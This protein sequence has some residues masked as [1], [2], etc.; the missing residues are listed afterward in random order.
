MWTDLLQLVR[1]YACMR[2]NL[3]SCGKTANN[4]RNAKNSIHVVDFTSFVIN[5]LHQ[6]CENQNWCNL[7]FAGLFL[8]RLA[9]SLWIKSLDNQRAS[10]PGSVDN[11][12]Q[13]CYHQAGASDANASWYR[14]D[15]WKAKSLLLKTSLLILPELFQLL[16][17]WCNNIVTTL[18]CQPCNILVISWLYQTC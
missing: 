4:A 3:A 1:F 15:D 6:V 17:S 12:Q 5:K 7:I 8:K 13:T 9:S 11:L 2:K 18:C 14:L 16:Q 10:K